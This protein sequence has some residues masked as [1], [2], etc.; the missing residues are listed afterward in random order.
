MGMKRARML[1]AALGTLIAAQPPAALAHHSFAMFDTTKK[2]TLVGT[3]VDFQWANPHAWLDVMGSMAGEPPRQ[4][5]LEGTSPSMLAR[6]G[7]TRTE[8]K[9]GDK[10]TVVFNPVRDGALN[11]ALSYVILADGRVLPSYGAPPAVAGAP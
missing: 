5:G 2:V 10:V 6:K 4:W 7:W 3:V 11:G 8:L 1:S 9:P